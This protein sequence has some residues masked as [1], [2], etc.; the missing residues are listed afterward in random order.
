[1]GKDR[2]AEIAS[3]LHSGKNK[4]SVWCYECG[5]W[6]IATVEIVKVSAPT[7]THNGTRNRHEWRLKKILE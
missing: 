3:L 7:K 4:A 5:E 6:G 2:V 1:M